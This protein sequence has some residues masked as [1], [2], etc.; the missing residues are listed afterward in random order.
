[1]ITEENFDINFY[2]SLTDN[3]SD[4]VEE[5]NDN[6]IENNE[7]EDYDEDDSYDYDDWNE[8]SSERGAYESDEDYE[9]R[10]EDLDNFLDGFL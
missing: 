1:M 3:P 2:L 6:E 7:E 4:E 10:Q 9:E 5:I 8:M